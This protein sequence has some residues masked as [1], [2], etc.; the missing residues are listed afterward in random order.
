MKNLIIILLFLS[1]TNCKKHQDK[2]PI[3]NKA[4]LTKDKVEKPDQNH[5]NWK[6]DYQIKTKAISNYNQ[7]EIDLLYLHLPNKRSGLGRSS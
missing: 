3:N 4:S 1:L 2:I 5:Q 6:G 7:K